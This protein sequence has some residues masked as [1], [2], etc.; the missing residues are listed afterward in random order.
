[1]KFTV[2][3]SS[4]AE[5]LATVQKGIASASTLPILSGVLIHAADGV[6]EFQTSN[7]TIAI[8]HRV[9]ALVE[10]EGD[11]VVPCKM[12]ANITKTLPDAPVSFELIERQVTIR[13]EKSSFRLNTL[14]VGDFPEFPSY[15]L[16]STVE[17]PANVLSDMVSRVWRVCSTDK[18][19][20]VL[21]GVYMT[22]ENNT[23]R[24]VATDS[25]RLA[26]CDTQVETSSLDGSFELNVPADAFNDALS[27]TGG[28]G[29]IM[30]G[31][32]DTQV[33]FESGN[34]TYVSRRIEGVYPNYKALLP[35]SCATTVKINVDAISSALKRVATIAQNNSAVKFDVDPDAGTLALSAISSDQDVARETLDV[36]IEGAGGTI[37]FNYHYI[38][39]CLNALSREKEITLELKSYTQAGVFKSYDKINYL[40]LV[41]PV[42]I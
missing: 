12:L 7:Y 34:T 21:N 39:G 3:Q 36:E 26:V 15:A 22:V 8:R 40:Y 13:C 11:M 20:P 5:A 10:E 28:H 33:V 29:T 23:I 2:S 42:R 19:R 25:Y 27:V 14:P 41:M 1:M 16:E 30:I 24:L 17:L 6:L 9:A 4:L 35:D 32:T 37:A 18:N 38:F 31:S